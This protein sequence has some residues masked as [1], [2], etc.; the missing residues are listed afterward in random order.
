MPSKI[1]ELFL[2]LVLDVLYCSLP[3]SL[4]LHTGTD[5]RVLDI[6]MTSDL[7]FFNTHNHSGMLDRTL[8]SSGHLSLGLPGL[9]KGTY[10]NV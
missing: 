2:V 9:A 3:K 6:G 8:K 4:Q 5:C 1:L 10:D 7:A